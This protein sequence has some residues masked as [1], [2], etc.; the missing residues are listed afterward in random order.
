MVTR[1]DTLGMVRVRFK[2][3]QR[4]TAISELREHKAVHN[5]SMRIYRRRGE[6]DEVQ[7]AATKEKL[8]AVD[9][10]LDQ[11]QGSEPGRPM[12]IVAPIWL[13]QSQVS[14]AAGVAIE[15]LA[16]TIDALRTGEMPDGRPVADGRA[17]VR[18]AMKDARAWTKTLLAAYEFPRQPLR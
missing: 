13:V 14:G 11:A 5:E 3:S 17:A 6:R 8:E 15:D 10:A 9:R 18:R 2:A 12:E 16:G 7:I 1:A 4:E